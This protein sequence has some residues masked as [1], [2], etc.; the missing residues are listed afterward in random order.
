MQIFVLIAAS[1]LI[2]SVIV[3]VCSLF[4]IPNP[5]GESAWVLHMGIFVVWFPAVIV[6]QKITRD[7]PQKDWWK[8]ALRGCP[9]WM[10]KMLYFF[11]GYA[12]LNF[13]IFIVM[14]VTGGSLPASE[15]DTPSSIFKGFSGHWM[16]FYSAA[17]AILYSY[18]HVKDRDISRRCPNGHQVPPLVKFCPECGSQIR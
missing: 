8:A 14:D 15:G 10:K 11:F 18:T 13:I 12:I 1:G 9:N 5:L 2:L 6:A 16:A 4:G 3:H 17:L 7:V